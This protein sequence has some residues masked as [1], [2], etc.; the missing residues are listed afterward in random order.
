M[1]PRRAVV[2]G[3]GGEVELAD[4]ARAGDGGVVDLVQR[5]RAVELGGR[6]VEA[7]VLVL[8]A[9]DGLEDALGL[10]DAHDL[11]GRAVEQRLVA[12]VKAARTARD[13]VVAAACATRTTRA[14]R[15]DRGTRGTGA[16]RGIGS[17][18][19]IGAAVGAQ[20][21][22]QVLALEHWHGQKLADVTGAPAR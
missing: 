20:H 1:L 22:A 7:L 2:G 9:L 10:D 14:A 6:A 18:G 21:A 4:A 12:V 5:E 8:R 3:D 15:A 11:S 19:P 13:P 17:L 16:G